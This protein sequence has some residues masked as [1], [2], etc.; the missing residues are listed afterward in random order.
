M[1]RWT[2]LPFPSPQW[3]APPLQAVAFE[4][5]WGLVVAF[6]PQCLRSTMVDPLVRQ[7]SPYA[8]VHMGCAC[9]ASLVFRPERLVRLAGPN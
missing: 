9:G 5:P 2:Q 1:A 8:E 4:L 7:V 3:W 6:C